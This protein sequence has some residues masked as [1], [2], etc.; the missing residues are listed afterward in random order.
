[1]P[2]TGDKD[3]E[4]VRFETELRNVSQ[5]SRYQARENVIAS[6]VY[7]FQVSA[8]EQRQALWEDM[9]K[10][11]QQ[12]AENQEKEAE[13]AES[14]QNM[15]TSEFDAE[16]L[17]YKAAVEQLDLPPG[18]VEDLVEMFQSNDAEFR[19]TLWQRVEASR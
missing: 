18:M 7:I 10:S 6:Q 17:R 16:T 15:D 14:L 5:Q 12:L 3:A 1:M 19:K 11:K 9:E 2:E 8:P 13:D 4:T